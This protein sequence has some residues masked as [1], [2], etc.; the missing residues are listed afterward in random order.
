MSNRQIALPEPNG[1][2]YDIVGTLTDEEQIM[3]QDVRMFM[4]TEVAP[5]INEY[6]QRDEFPQQ[7]I[8]GLAKLNVIGMP[9]EGY[10][11]PG[12][13][14]LMEGLMAME[15]ARVDPSF[16]TFI[17][18][19]GGLAMGTIYQCGSEEQK[20]KWLP[21]MQKLEII[22]AFGLTE[23]YSGSDVARGLRTT[24]RFDE[25]TNEWVLN[26]QKKWI[27]NSTFSDIV[28]VWARDEADDQVKCFIVEKD[29]PGFHVEK[30]M[31]KIA[32]RAVENGLIT[33]KNCRVTEENRL[34]NANSFRDTANVLRAT[35]AGVAWM[36]VGC[37][38]G[39]YEL[40]VKYTQQRVQFGKPIARYQMTQDK[41]ATMLG[42]VTAGMLMCM[43]LSQMQEAGTMTDEQASLAKMFTTVRMRETVAL[44]RDV[45]GGNGIL[46]ENHIARLFSDAEAIYS[47]EGTRE[48][49]ALIVGRAVTGLSAFV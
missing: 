45:L 20:Q 28:T 35:R 21:P 24:A 2:F 38:R 36:A 19:Q 1:D 30:I 8:P 6:W 41:L 31:G 47:Y 25:E 42:N 13:G 16:A 34:Q 27:G 3:L 26:G 10:E 15:A 48:V 43:R 23:P 22:G 5:V 39:A 32:L 17:G 44:A 33:L 37:M 7:L 9:F 14:A 49:N 29:N 12:K 11:C 4:E 40:A 18:V 46:I